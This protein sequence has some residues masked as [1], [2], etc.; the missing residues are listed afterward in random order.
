MSGITIVRAFRNNS[1]LIKI[2][3]VRDIQ[4]RYK[5][6]MMGIAWSVL[7]PL[8][9]LAIYT[10]VFSQIFKTRWGIT[11]NSDGSIEFAL[12][13][14]AGLVVFNMFAECMTRSPMLI[15]ENPSYVKKIK[16]PLEVLGIMVTGSALF[17]ALT[18]I[19]I[20][21]IGLVLTN[22]RL[23]ASILLLPIVWIPLI[24]WLLGLMA[25]ILYMRI[26]KRSQAVSE[27]N[28]K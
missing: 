11:N 17:H 24:L 19:L 7:N 25:S 21:V 28:N 20:L 22:S 16:F 14:F 8:L 26:C 9:M 4:G 1:D 3:I 2:F 5:G 12:N 13:L 10:L 18:S 27:F 23:E 6:S 15:L